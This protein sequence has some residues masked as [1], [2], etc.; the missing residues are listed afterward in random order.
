MQFERCWRQE[1]VDKHRQTLLAYVDLL[2]TE[3]TVEGV[4][5]SQFVES[6]LERTASALTELRISLRRLKIQFLDHV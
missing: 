2:F 5:H 1:D 4:K 3:L 6:S